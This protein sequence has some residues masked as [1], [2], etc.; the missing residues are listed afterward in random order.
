MKLGR[1][2]ANLI[3][4]TRSC[5]QVSFQ[6]DV[7]FQV[8]NIVPPFSYISKVHIELSLKWNLILC[9]PCAAFQDSVSPVKIPTSL[10]WSISSAEIGQ[11]ITL[12]RR[13]INEGMDFAAHNVSSLVLPFILETFIFKN[14]MKSAALLQICHSE[15]CD[16][17]LLR[18]FQGHLCF[19]NLKSMLCAKW[20]VF[21]ET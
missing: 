13:T 19:L 20:K 12:L 15:D 16:R 9:S 7:G 11:G 8:P 17:I 2:V 3:F 10:Q 1:M 5:F 21:Q 4:L 14:G 6:N 18:L